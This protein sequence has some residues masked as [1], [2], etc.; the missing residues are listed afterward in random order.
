MSFGDCRD[1]LLL[2]GPCGEAGYK[3]MVVWN[4]TIKVL[5]NFK[6]APKFE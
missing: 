2:Q 6:M 4:L 3:K 1:L 5:L